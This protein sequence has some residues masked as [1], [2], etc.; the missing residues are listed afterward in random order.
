MNTELQ[1][2]C[3]LLADN[4][5]EVRRAFPMESD[6][7]VIGVAAMFTS[8]D[9]RADADR[10]RDCRE[11]LKSRESAFSPLRGGVVAPLVGRMALSDHP[12]EI[13]HSVRELDGLLKE[14]NRR[15]SSDYRAL[16]ALILAE[17]ADY[18]SQKACT[19]KTM[20]IFRGIKKAHPVLYSE[21]ALPMAAVLA[22][23]GRDPDLLLAEM[24]EDYEAV[25]RVFRDGS[26]ALPVSYVMSLDRRSAR[27]KTDRLQALWEELKR[28]GHRYGR[29]VELTTLAILSSVNE[30]VPALAGEVAEADD[31]QKTKKGFGSFSMGATNRRMCAAQTV[32]QT[33]RPGEDGDSGVLLSALLAIH[34]EQMAA[35]TAAAVSASTA[36][37]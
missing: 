12:G 37:H 18:P 23:S 25:R 31:L 26:A 34:M 19:G 4:R 32:L 11:Y 2:R 8:E 36:A 30:P 22:A 3:D 27:E 29:G 20:A 6:L 35:M 15:I 14:E 28:I 9:V 16:A 24:E 13:L 10:L 17:F 1:R 7:A 33:R 5:E 21:N